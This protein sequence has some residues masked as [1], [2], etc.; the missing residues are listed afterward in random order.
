MMEHVFIS[1][2]GARRDV[3]RFCREVALSEPIVD[4]PGGSTVDFEMLAGTAQHALAERLI[5]ELRLGPF[6]RRRYESTAHE[7]ATEPFFTSYGLSWTDDE[8]KIVAKPSYSGK[9]A[10]PKCGKGGAE[11]TAPLR[12]HAEKLKACFIRVPPGLF[13]ASSRVIDLIAEEDWTGTSSAP[14][15][16]RTSGLEVD[17]YRQLLVRSVLPP[18]HQDAGIKPSGIPGACQDCRRLGYQL[19]GVQAVYP[20][21]VQKCA[22]DWNVSEEWLAPHFVSCP[23]LVCSRRVVHALLNLQP[24]QVWLPVRWVD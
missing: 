9:D 20:R 22:M 19:G 6:R 10:C 18:M 4:R 16:D 14:I 17:S 1:V 11:L 12:V 15:L 3:D 13:L 2:L 23:G 7:L 21:S 24:K 8:F 5:E